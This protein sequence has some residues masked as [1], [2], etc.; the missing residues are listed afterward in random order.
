[1]GLDTRANSVGVKLKTDL[2]VWSRLFRGARLRQGF[3]AS[4][5]NGSTLPIYSQYR[6]MDRTVQVPMLNDS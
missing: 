3:R 6:A 1:M 2:V 5:P 4:W